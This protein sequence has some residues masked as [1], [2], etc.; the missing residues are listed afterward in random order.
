MRGGYFYKKAWMPK[1]RQY[2][3]KNYLFVVIKPSAKGKFLASYYLKWRNLIKSFLGDLLRKRVIRKILKL[4]RHY[5]VQ[6]SNT[7]AISIL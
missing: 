4:D 7:T 6:E 3:S 1:N 2:V 5:R